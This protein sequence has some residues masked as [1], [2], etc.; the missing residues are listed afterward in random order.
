MQSEQHK[1]H[2]QSRNSHSNC[3]ECRADTE[4]RFVRLK[5]WREYQ[6]VVDYL[7]YVR[8]RL[9]ACKVD[10]SVDARIWYRK[11][12]Q[13]LHRRITLRAPSAGRK[14]CDS[15]QERLKQFG[16]KV[17]AGYLRKFAQ[18]GASCLDY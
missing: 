11:F 13:A 4:R 5:P 1:I 16:R 12:A 18:R 14:Y 15:Y 10:N 9:A 2:I 17:D 7:S 3:C 6:F 8:P